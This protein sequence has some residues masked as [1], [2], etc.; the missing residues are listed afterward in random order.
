MT[1]GE[2]DCMATTITLP[3]ARD[4]DL[5]MVLLFLSA[6]T[7][8]AVPP[9][10]HEFGFNRG[11]VA[12]FSA[13]LGGLLMILGILTVFFSR[14]A[15]TV[16]SGEI[17]VKDGFFNKPLV[18]K[19]SSPPTFR[20]SG[21]EEDGKV[22]GNEVWTVHMVDDDKQYLIDRRV[23]EQTSSRSLAERLAKAVRGSMI[24][25]HNGRSYEF[26]TEELDLSF[27][28]RV[29]RYPEMLGQEIDEPSDKVIELQ[30]TDTGLKVQWSLMRSGLLFEL[31]C[32]SA[33]L[34]AAAFVPLPGGPGGNAFSLYDVEKAEGD[35]RYFIGVAVFT[36]VS[37]VILAGYRNTLE[38][39]IPKRAQSRTTIWGVPVRGGR[40]ALEDLEHVAVSITSRGPYLQLISD[41]KILRERLP[42][43]NIAN[44]LGWE[45]RK[46]LSETT[47]E[48]TSHIEQSV[49]MSAF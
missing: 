25:T 24:E 44:W 22:L 13:P 17:R 10:A 16:E 46:R 43:T 15:V 3:T 14:K 49:E 40:I 35:Y 32:V 29:H 41:T 37:I 36:L 12:M 19:Y 7:Y 28:E 33:F 9:L 6:V 27:V 4:R 8:F 23:G 42:A 20:L 2:R 48:K 21:F 47:P 11:A 18:L 31:L 26:S 38:I 34:V 30:R 5:G 39:I 1:T 45:I